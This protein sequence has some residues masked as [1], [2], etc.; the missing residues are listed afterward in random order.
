[1]KEGKDAELKVRVTL[2][3]KA[4]VI[5]LA[6]ERGE[7]ESLIVREALVEYFQSRGET[8]NSLAAPLGDEV[9]ARLVAPHKEARAASPRKS[10]KRARKPRGG[11]PG[12][13]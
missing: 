4:K 1:M 7:S 5:A 9:I 8:I 2:S 10:A 6:E 13:T 11:E 3:L 12:Q